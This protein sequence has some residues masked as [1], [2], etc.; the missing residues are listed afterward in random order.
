MEFWREFFVDSKILTH[1][2][3]RVLMY[4][5]LPYEDIISKNKEPKL[6]FYKYDFSD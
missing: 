1:A 4:F 2:R 3:D 5:N 6:T